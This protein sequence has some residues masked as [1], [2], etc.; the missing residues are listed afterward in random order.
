M[1]PGCSFDWLFRLLA[2]E[3]CPMLSSF[4]HLGWIVLPSPTGEVWY[5]PMGVTT[6]YRGFFAKT[7]NSKSSFFEVRLRMMRSFI[8]S[9]HAT[10]N[11]QAKIVSTF[12]EQL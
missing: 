3:C 6:C 11:R 5:M 1:W 8:S 10:S 7:A 9:N 12:A 4:V 2:C